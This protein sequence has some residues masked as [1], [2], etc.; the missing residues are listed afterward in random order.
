MLPIVDHEMTIQKER[1]IKHQE[2][3]A[4][5]TTMHL[6]MHD[7]IMFIHVHIYTHICIF[8]TLSDTCGPKCDC[9]C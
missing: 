8:I 2:E 4:R 5:G 7:L 6:P 9:V 1:I 3:E